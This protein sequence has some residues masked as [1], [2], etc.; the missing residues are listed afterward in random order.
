MTAASPAPSGGR[1]ATAE[2]LMEAYVRDAQL[3]GLT[4]DTLAT[5]RSDLEYY[6]EWLDVH[7]VEID[8]DELREFLYHLRNEKEGRGGKKGLADNT[9]SSYFSALNGFY[10]FLAFEEIIEENIV[11]VFRDRYLDLDHDRTQSNRQ[12]ISVEEMAMLIHATLKVRDCALILLL[13]KTGIRRGECVNI[14]LDDIDWEQQS[15]RLDPTPKRTNTLVFFDGETARVLER[16]VKARAEEEPDTDALFINQSQN[17]LKRHGIFDAVTSRAEA[18][19]LHDSDSLDPQDRFTPHCCR[20]W[21]TTHLR[22]S[23]MQRE[24]IQVLRGDSRRDA[25]DIYDHIDEQELR[26]AYLAHIPTLGI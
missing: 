18:V 24:F 12:L 9:L 21:F 2:E 19:D 14:D 11:P 8:Y 15:I 20:H 22:R 4:E 25:I 1:D 10:K 13:A 23:G 16:W 17:R 7:P 6:L 26:E 3:Q 5:Y